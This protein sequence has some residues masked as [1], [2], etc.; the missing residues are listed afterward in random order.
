MR[1]FV[2]IAALLIGG[3]VFATA[4]G[5][6]KGM[7]LEQLKEQGVIEAGQTPFTY[8]A[9]KLK[10]GHDDFDFYLFQLT[11]SQG[12][13]SIKAWSKRVKTNVYGEQI[14]SKYKDL[15]QALIGKYGSPS[16]KFDRLKP[17]SIWNEPKDWMTAM[18]KKERELATFW[19]NTNNNLQ[20][21]LQMIAMSVTVVRRDEASVVIG[22]DFDNI[23]TCRSEIRSGRNRNL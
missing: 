22:Y 10:N 12:L 9:S 17:G 20:D 19:R 14:L 2:A 15:E 13:C 16:A 18:D 23:E 21:S 8:T 7:T 1:I 3:N 6:T 11:P 4:F 5:L